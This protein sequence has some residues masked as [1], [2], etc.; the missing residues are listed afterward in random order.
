MNKLLS[1]IALSTL[2]LSANSV[3]AGEQIGFSKANLKMKHYEP[4][5]SNK[6]K[7]CSELTADEQKTNKTC[8]LLCNKGS[9][10][11]YKGYNYIFYPA[12][13]GLEPNNDKPYY[14]KQ[15]AN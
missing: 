9:K 10:E 6:I 12:H 2:V 4:T 1:I 7:K 14:I 5:P 3:Y 15:K 13:C 11:Y 8:S